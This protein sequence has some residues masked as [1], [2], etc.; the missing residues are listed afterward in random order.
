MYLFVG[1]GNIGKKYEETPHNAGF[2]MLDE[3]RDFFG[4][5][6]VFSVDDWTLEKLAEAQIAFLRADG[7]KRAV[8]AKPTTFMN[9]SGR[10]VRQLV[11]M[12]DVDVK[13][14][15]I[16]IHDDLD[17]PLGEYKVQRGVGPKGHNGVNSV[18]NNVGTTEF[19]R[20]RIGVETRE[21]EMRKNM[22]GEDFVLRKYNDDEQVKLREVISDS[23][24]SLRSFIQF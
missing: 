17:L 1:L 18:V 9:A 8:L 10:S 20:V 14:E 16:L 23:V 4:Y 22:P 15:L 3:L 12:Y 6:S 7:S 5:D 19:I 11:K 13:T 2:M 21:G 24:K